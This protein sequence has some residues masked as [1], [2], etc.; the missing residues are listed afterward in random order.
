MRHLLVA[1]VVA[2]G[3]TAG[4]ANAQ[5]P[6]GMQDSLAERGGEIVAMMDH[7][8]MGMMGGHGGSSGSHSG[9]A[10]NGHSDA[11]S[12]GHSGSASGGHQQEGHAG[13][14]GAG[15]M[16]EWQSGMSTHV[17]P[18]MQSV[19]NMGSKVSQMMKQGMSPAKMKLISEIMDEL[20]GHLSGMSEM[21]FKGFAS[22]DEMHEMHMRINGT[23]KR[24]EAMN[25]M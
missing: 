21:M 2:A 4:N 16:K 11:A 24:M 7:N 17:V 9:S 19:T 15:E 12:G 18:M 3:L 22:E 25:K 20:S 1:T 8:H 14:G 13:H 5:S 6:V 10:S 23:M